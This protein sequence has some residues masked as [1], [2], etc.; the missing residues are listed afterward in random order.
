MNQF[1]YFRSKDAWTNEDL[2]AQ[3]L[4][5]FIKSDYQLC[6][7]SDS[8]FD[9]LEIKPGES[10]IVPIQIMMSDEI[11]VTTENADEQ[12]EN[13]RNSDFWR[14]EDYD[15]RDWWV[16]TGDTIEI[17]QGEIFY[18]FYKRD[19]INE[20]IDKRSYQATGNLNINE[21]DGFDYRICVDS[22]GDDKY[23]DTGLGTATE[24]KTLSGSNTF[25]SNTIQFTL[26]TSLYTDPVSYE[27]EFT[28]TS[29]NMFSVIKKSQS[30]TKYNSIVK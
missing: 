20:S 6:V 28:K 4:F 19:W 18:K 21:G 2:N 30:T 27:V 22:R 25:T 7:N 12:R 14:G 8:K 13:A 26:R 15:Y 5:P 10:I 3:Q 11:W 16:Y 29:D 24:V 23:Y 9:Y 1:L 17:N